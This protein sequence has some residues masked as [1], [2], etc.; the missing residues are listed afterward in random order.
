M[1]SQVVQALTQRL[2]GN[3]AVPP[4]AAANQQEAG[5][6][7]APGSGPDWT[8]PVNLHRHVGHGAAVLEG[9]G[10]SVAPAT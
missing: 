9:D 2:R 1:V 8:L 3:P 4:F 7:D 10:R 6:Q 5:L